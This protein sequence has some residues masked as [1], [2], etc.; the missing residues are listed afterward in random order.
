[1]WQ[2]DATI[3]VD[4]AVI[5]SI[6]MGKVVLMSGLVFF[7]WFNQSCSICPP[8]DLVVPSQSTRQIV[9]ER[10]AAVVVTRRKNIDAWMKTHLASSQDPDDADGG[11]AVP[12]SVDGY[13]LTA[14][15]V[16]ARMG[17]RNVFIISGRGQRLTVDK[18][19]VVWRSK[20]SDIALLHI[21]A[22][23]PYFYEWTP[24]EQ[25]LPEGTRVIHGGISTGAKS[26]AGKL[27]TTLA[28][29]GVLTGNRSF[30]LDIP[31]QPG[32]SGGPVVDAYGHLVGINSAVEFLVPMETAFFVDSEANRPNTLKIQELIK[33]DRLQNKYPNTP[34]E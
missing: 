18:A 2:V 28:P 1:M 33:K 26:T 30:K 12:I 16:L 22:P 10:T 27:C 21:P 13:F 31:F 15:H 11:S 8:P 25:W 23:T 24:R 9:A 29:E 17:G 20:A 3:R 14:D 32:D 6:Q 34:H 4:V 7:S 5:L 19:R